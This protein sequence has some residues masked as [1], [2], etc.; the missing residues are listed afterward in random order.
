MRS[1]LFLLSFALAAGALSAQTPKWAEGYPSQYDEMCSLVAGELSRDGAV[2]VEV[3]KAEGTVRFT[4][5]EPALMNLYN[6]FV[7]CMT[8]Q[9]DKWPS[10]VKDFVEKSL[11]TARE[12]RSALALL[13]TYQTGR[14]LLFI[15]IYPQ[16]YADQ[17]GGRLIGTA[18]FPGTL[19]AVV[20]D[21]PSSIAPL[22]PSYLGK[23]KKGQDEVIASAKTNTFA[24]MK[25]MSPDSMD[26]G[27][28]QTLVSY[29]DEGN[30]YMASLA[31]DPAL[32]RGHE[33]ALGAFV[34]I[35]ARSVCVIQPI[36]DKAYVNSLGFNTMMTI[37][38]LFSEQGGSIS[39]KL[40]WSN[41]G[42]IYLAG[43]SLEGPLGTLSLPAELAALMR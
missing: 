40:Y 31:L 24:S 13:E 14:A 8:N 27:S 41:K 11:A 23:W 10:L 4:V 21:M 17:L 7:T 29:W 22:D 12:Q 35:P 32:I 1:L 3:Q 6:I 36:S 43:D 9:R 20:V 16:E 26:L 5:G 19:S 37:K 28:G 39:A 30:I 33:G 2:S 34:G 42:K 38:D 15:K 18:D 25:N